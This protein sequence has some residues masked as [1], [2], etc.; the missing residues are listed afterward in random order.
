[1]QNSAIN[2]QL[3]LNDPGLP[4]NSPSNQANAA[5]MHSN[6]NLSNNLNHISSN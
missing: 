5:P 1:M 2:Q 3:P 6:P 4:K